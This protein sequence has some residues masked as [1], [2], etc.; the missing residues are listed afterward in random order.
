MEKILENFIADEISYALFYN[1]LIKIA[2]TQEDASMLK[3]FARDAA[4]HANTF[5]KIYRAMTGKE[6]N[7]IIKMPKMND[8]Y[9]KLLKDSALKESRSYKKYSEKYKI[10]NNNTALKN[11]LFDAKTDSGSHALQIL[12]ML[13]N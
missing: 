3:E 13:S 6:S 7:A 5:K 8:E 1:E 2:P 11:A 9:E 4:Y 12:Y 10:T